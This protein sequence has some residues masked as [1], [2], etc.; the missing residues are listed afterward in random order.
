MVLPVNHKA[1]P[2][3]TLRKDEGP[4]Q[5][6]CWVAERYMCF[7]RKM[8]LGGKVWGQK[9]PTWNGFLRNTGH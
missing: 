8:V 7:A 3:G 1:P 5:E 9:W 6:Q 2:V 4:G